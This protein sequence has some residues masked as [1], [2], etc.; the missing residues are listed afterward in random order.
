MQGHELRGCLSKLE[1]VRRCFGPEAS[2]KQS[3]QPMS[4]SLPWTGNTIPFCCVKSVCSYLLQQKCKTST[5]ELRA[6]L[7]DHLVKSLPAMEKIWV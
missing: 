7:V 2:R 1:Q 5:V 4:V 3:F 6:S